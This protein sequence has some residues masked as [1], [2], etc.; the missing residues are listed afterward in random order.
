MKVL[1]SQTPHVQDLHKEHQYLPGNIEHGKLKMND[2]KVG[3]LVGV[4]GCCILSFL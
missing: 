2:D 1:E 3:K 4:E